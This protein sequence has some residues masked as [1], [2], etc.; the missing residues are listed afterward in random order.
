MKLA[1]FFIVILTAAAAQAAKEIEEED[2]G[3][4]PSLGCPEKSLFGKMM[5]MTFYWGI[6]VKFLFEGAHVTTEG[7]Y[8][9]VWFI[10]VGLCVLIEFLN[11]I[12][13]NIQAGVY[14]NLDALIEKGDETVYKVSC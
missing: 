7:M 12:R 2:N 13:F 9:L 6:E 5:Q 4:H 8:T 14:A 10:T 3:P 1:P 11:Y